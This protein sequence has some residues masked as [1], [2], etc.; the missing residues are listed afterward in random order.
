M[1]ETHVPA[2][3]TGVA[4]C[5]LAFQSLGV[6]FGDVGTS[7]LYVLSSTFSSNPS[8]HDILGALSLIFWTLILIPLVKYALIVMNAN[9]NGNGGTFALYSFICRHVKVSQLPPGQQYDDDDKDVSLIDTSSCMVSNRYLHRAAK[10]RQF[11]EGNYFVK[12]ILLIVALLG[13]CAVIGDG[14]LT[15]SISVRSA[16]DGIQ[17][18]FPN[19]SLDGVVWISIVILIFLFCLQRFGT[20]KV[21]W[22]FAPFLLLWFVCIFAIGIYNIIIHDWRVVYAFNPYYIVKYFMERRTQAWISLGGIILCVT[23]TEAMFADVSH[24]S[25]ASVRRALTY[26]VIPSLIAAYFG[27]GA[28]LMKHPE[29]AAQTFFK[30]IPPYNFIFW[31]M[32]AISVISAV[33]ASQ[34]MISATFSIVEQSQALGCFPRVKVVHTSKS[35]LGQVYVPEVNWTLMVLCILIVGFF[36]TTTLLGN[37]YGIAVVAVMM[38]TTSLLTLIMLFIWQTPL[39]L[40][41]AFP[42]VF[43]TIELIYF[44]SNLYKFT[45][46]GYIPIVFA[47]ILLLIMCTWQYVSKKKFELETRD[48]SLLVLQTGSGGPSPVVVPGIG[49]VYTR[50]VNGV[51]PVYKHFLENVHATHAVLVLVTIKTL[52][53]PI[54]PEAER[55]SISKVSEE[56]RLSI[57]RVPRDENHDKQYV[58]R[59]VARYGYMEG[60]SRARMASKNGP[61]SSKVNFEEA[62][63]AS[64]KKQILEL[65]SISSEQEVMQVVIEN[66]NDGEQR[67][68]S[69][70]NAV[71]K[72][73]HNA[74]HYNVAASEAFREVSF[75]E[76]CRKEGGVT[77]MLGKA[78]VRAAP[79]SSRFKRFVVDVLYDAIYRMCRTSSLTLPVPPERLLKVAMTYEI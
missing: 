51:P 6:V 41:I 10:I 52:Q 43:L 11:L 33:I 50:Q 21:G 30:S 72:K 39:Y 70:I 67:S 32:F 23:G 26:I 68:T 74:D 8:Y 64:L 14:V 15:P 1:Q 59:C 71:G 29:D 25:V 20:A 4:I 13:T 22:L 3:A 27:Q 56:E 76:E 34:A 78:E 9:D 55:F 7:P 75:L 37:A 66:R 31:P 60:S 24:F 35:M 61:N 63:I 5:Y 49:L 19:L 54:V 79:Q 44:T 77:Y 16:M 73:R 69:N 48:D 58:Y 65:G 38:V 53:V 45:Q 17:T 28:Y 62:L 2:A 18:K 12:Q 36:K 47:G 57:T 40:A 46:G 42:F